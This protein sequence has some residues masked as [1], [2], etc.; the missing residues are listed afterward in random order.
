MHLLRRAYDRILCLEEKEFLF[1][2]TMP[3]AF[4]T[5]AREMQSRRLVL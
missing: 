3:V 2:R 1:R 4:F 5:P